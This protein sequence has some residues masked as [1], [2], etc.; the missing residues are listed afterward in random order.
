M[1]LVRYEHWAERHFHKFLVDSANT[2]FKWGVNDCATFAANAIQSF[3]GTDIASDF[4]GKY[5]TKIGAAKA[6]KTITGGMTTEDAVVYAANKNGLVERKYP[7]TAQRGDL[8]LLDNA[9]ELIAGVVHLSGRS[10]T[11]V[12]DKG[13]LN[14][15]VTTVKRSWAV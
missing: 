11:S 9:G 3:T 6:I 10:V 1:P 5:T 2:P 13:T 15:P 7:L 4:R 12:T 14:L 8:V